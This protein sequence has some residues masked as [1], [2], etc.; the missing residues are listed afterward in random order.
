MARRDRLIA[1]SSAAGAQTVSILRLHHKP[2]VLLFVQTE[3]R[4][5]SGLGCPLVRRFDSPE[6][7]GAPP[8]QRDAPGSKLGGFARLRGSAHRTFGKSGHTK[9]QRSCMLGASRLGAVTI[10][11]LFPFH[12]VCLAAV[13]L[14]QSADAI[15]AFAGAFGAFDAKHVELALDVAEDEVSTRH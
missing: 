5:G 11:L 1:S 2:L 8:Q 3:L 9:S 12:H 7:V 10:E 14:D 4:N 13:F 15:A 6:M